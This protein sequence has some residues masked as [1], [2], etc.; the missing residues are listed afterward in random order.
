MAVFL[1][2]KEGK[3]EGKKSI[4]SQ[5]IGFGFRSFFRHVGLLIITVLAGAGFALLVVAFFALFIVLFFLLVNKGQPRVSS[6][7]LAL[8]LL[9]LLISVIVILMI[10][11][12]IDLGFKKITLELYDRDESSVKAMF[13][14][15]G[16]V[17]KAFVGWLLYSAM[18]LVGLLFFIVPGFILL[19]RFGFFPY[20]II[21]KNVG[22]VAAL[23]MSYDITKDNGWDIFL[24]WIANKLIVY[25]GRVMVIGAVVTSPSI[26]LAEAFFYRK[27][28]LIKTENYNVFTDDV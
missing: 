25:I 23:K 3:M 12:G 4:V 26:A 21:D 11:V 18:I 24:F 6:M 7:V 16:L 27:L 5:A 20:F 8:Q 13:S 19:L 22:P 17:P 9:P 2:K 14:C 15:F 1:Y 10:F 28:L